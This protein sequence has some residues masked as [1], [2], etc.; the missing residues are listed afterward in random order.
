MANRGGPLVGE[1]LLMLQGIPAE[2]LLLT[3]E[4]EANLKVSRRWK[5]VA[6]CR[7]TLDFTVNVCTFVLRILPA[8]E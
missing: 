5:C 2:D 4:S 1:E 8:T 3:K 7:S 6:F